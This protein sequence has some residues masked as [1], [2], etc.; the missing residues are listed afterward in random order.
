MGGPLCIHGPCVLEIPK[1]TT[2]VTRF[3]SASKD[4]RP[5]ARGLRFDAEFDA[6]WLAARGE[7]PLRA[8]PSPAVLPLVA[9]NLAGGGRADFRSVLR[10]KAEGGAA[11]MSSDVAVVRWRVVVSSALLRPHVNLIIILGMS[12]YPAL[13]KDTQMHPTHKL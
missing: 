12:V 2:G 13:T 9:G 11:R 6:H 1:R 10:R 8:G 3:A 7:G 4:L 5:Q